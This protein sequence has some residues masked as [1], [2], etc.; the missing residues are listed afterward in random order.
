VSASDYQPIP[1]AIHSRYELAII[2]RHWLRLRWRD[3]DGLDHVD[4]LRPLDLETRS[5]EEF[6]IAEHPDHG[7]ERIRLDR[8]VDFSVEK[9]P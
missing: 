5:G 8:I 6:L 3:D 2:E 9:Q 4:Q 7:R 1:C